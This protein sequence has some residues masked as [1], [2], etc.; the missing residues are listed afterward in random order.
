MRRFFSFWWLCTRTAAGG[1]STFANDW[2]WVF[3]NPAVSAFGT[4]AI[5]TLGGLAPSFVARLGITE[6]TTGIS[7]LDSFLGALAA[8]AITWFAAFA[9]RLIY[10]PVTLFH[11]QKDRADK[12]DG[13]TPTAILS[14]GRKPIAALMARYITDKIPIQRQALDHEADSLQA[15]QDV[16]IVFNGLTAETVEMTKLMNR[17]NKKINSARDPQKK[18]H[19][20]KNLADHLNNYS[21]RIGE[22]AA[23]IRGMTP[24]LLECTSR[25][26]ERTAPNIDRATLNSFVTAVDGNVESI[27]KNMESASGVVQTISENFR[28]VTHDLDNA[29]SRMESVMGDLNAGLNEYKSAC[30]QIRALANERF[31]DGK[32]KLAQVS[33]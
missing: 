28:G 6:M 32:T 31:A 4:L 9:F 16:Q 14:K 13:I 33:I 10:A 24:V 17:N 2:Q 27:S 30:E 25:F 7:T 22:F 8:F 21:D 18:R 20:V 1:N 3:G 23:I 29:T 11:Q 19:A 15:V 26:L 5:A 12:L